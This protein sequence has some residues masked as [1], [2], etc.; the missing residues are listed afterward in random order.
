ME[1]DVKTATEKF[2]RLF[3]EMIPHI[4]KVEE[5]A[6]RPLQSNDMGAFLANLDQVEDLLVFGVGNGEAYHIFKPWLDQTKTHTLI[7]LENNLSVVKHLLRTKEGEEILTDPRVQIYPVPLDIRN[8]KIISRIAVQNFSRKYLLLKDPRADVVQFQNFGAMFKYNADSTGWFVTE[9]RTMGGAFYLNFY[10][11]LKTLPE[12]YSGRDLMGKYK[13]VPAFIVGAGPS[14]EK[15][16]RLLN[17]A[18]KKGIVFA[19]GTA[20]LAL[21]KMQ[22]KPTFGV[23]IDPNPSQQTRTADIDFPFMFRM[24]INA[25]ALNLLKGPKIHIPGAGGYEIVTWFEKE[26]GM[27]YPNFPEGHNVVNFMTTIALEMGCNPIIYVGLDLSFKGEQTYAEYEGDKTPLNKY[28]DL[29]QSLDIYG[30]KITTRWM[31]L[32]ERTYIYNLAQSFPHI[33]FYN[34]TEGGMVHLNPIPLHQLLHQLKPIKLNFD[35]KPLNISL[36]QIIDK[37]LIMKESLKD[38]K[39]ILLRISRAEDPTDP[40]WSGLLN[41]NLAYQTI[42]RPLDWY[43]GLAIDSCHLSYFIQRD[44]RDKYEGEIRKLHSY[45]INYLIK[46]VNFQYMLISKF[47]NELLIH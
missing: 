3:P 37:V 34:A 47:L 44:G 35:F 36:Q 41:E 39:E 24:R 11:N 43:A 42:I 20:I 6:A 9:F 31:W 22:V 14:L 7:F 13:D 45:K 10:H 16:G 28:T 15:N 1:Q 8:D 38:L 4:E 19:G 23:G 12:A 32:K 21:K 26:L 46:A 40:I 33:K 5:K 2:A 30:N 17:K 25:P 29:A 18:K 27:E